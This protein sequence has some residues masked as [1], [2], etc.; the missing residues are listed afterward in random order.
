MTDQNNHQDDNLDLD[1]VEFSSTDEEGIEEVSQAKM[2]K[3]RE[4]LKKATADKV[5]YL[6]GWQRAKADYINLQN[7]EDKNRSEII[8][9]AKEGLLV[10]LLPL[11]D[12]FDMAF[13]NKTVWEQ[14]PENWR[15]GI[16]Y[17][18]SQLTNIL[19]DNGLEPLV[20]PPG[21]DFDPQ[22]HESIGLIETN[23]KDEDGKILEVVK[24][25]YILQGKLIRPAQVKTGELK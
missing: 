8:K 5:E 13:A 10:D 16:E 25:G 15:K 3:L 18:Y 20:P 23:K 6:A 4:E 24:K 19:K 12:S 14:A 2:K 17:I 22:R 9:Y 21:S 7:T 1:E 11:V